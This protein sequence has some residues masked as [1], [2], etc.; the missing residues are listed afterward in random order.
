MDEGRGIYSVAMF[1]L[2]RLG[3]SVLEIPSLSSFLT[4]FSPEFSRVSHLCS[5][6]HGSEVPAD[7]QITLHRV[8]RK[9]LRV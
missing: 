3:F 6:L 4:K 2:K 7:G 5:L 9:L 8:S 1:H